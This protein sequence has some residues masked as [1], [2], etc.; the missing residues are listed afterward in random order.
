MRSTDAASPPLA[1][2]LLS[3][4][5]DSATTLAIAIEQGYQAH[6]LTVDY[7]QRH[8]I[9]IERA[10]V[11]ARELG[12]RQQ[13]NVKVELG[14]AGGSALTDPAMKVPDAPSEERIGGEIPLTYV[15]ARNTVFLAV[16]LAWAETLGAR[17]LF[18]GVNALD[19]SGYPDCRPAFLDAFERLAALATRAGVEGE[20]FRIHAPLLRLTKA[21]IIRRAVE[22]GVDPAHTL[23]CYAPGSRGEPCGRCESCVLRAKGFREAGLEDPALGPDPS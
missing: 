4:G 12:A 19:Y 22:L 1:V 5:L 7:G 18:L 6:A 2:V 8:R 23:S 13:R 15:P 14:F 9:E 3:G 21:A 11:L 20:R 16:G 17:D 10:A